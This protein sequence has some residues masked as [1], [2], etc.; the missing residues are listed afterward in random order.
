MNAGSLSGLES[1][2]IAE[3]LAQSQRLHR[4]LRGARVLVTGAT[5][6]FGTWLLDALVAI[7][8]A[9]SLDLRIVAVSRRPAAFAARHPRLHAACEIEWITA[10]VRDSTWTVAGPLTHVVHGATEASAKL[11]R[12]DPQRMFDTIVDGTRNVLRI[13]AADP[14]AKVLLVG[15]GA[16]Y[17]VQPANLQALSED[18]ALVSNPL[19]AT[20]AYAEGK[21]AAEH[22]AAIA[23]ASRSAHVKLARCFAFAGPH[24]PFDAHFAVGN[25]IRDAL[26][27]DAIR[28]AGN[29]LPR[30]SYL[31]PSD[32]VVWLLT[33]LVEGQAMRPYNVGAHESLSIR[34]LA[35]LCKVS[36]G[37]ATE[38][39]VVG[40]S[41]GSDYVPDTTRARTELGLEVRVPLAE[42]ID[43]TTA[44]RRR[45]H[46]PQPA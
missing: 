35:D 33:I 8:R 37:R 16:V 31:Y 22:L 20:Q 13:A 2:D 18:H 40:A 32:L 41:G 44:W 5:G 15:S 46:A 11:N 28:I 45:L 42:T 30:R 23:H 26:E 43:R 12:D 25:F 9:A 29:G 7:N 24:M 19:D 38:V 14:D 17:G 3:V 27:G 36:A 10:D 4:S 21:R 39:V 34:D 6:W 1:R